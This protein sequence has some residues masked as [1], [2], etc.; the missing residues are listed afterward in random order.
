MTISRAEKS[1]WSARARTLAK[2]LQSDFEL[3]A[4]DEVILVSLA[5][6][7]TREDECHGEMH[8]KPMT[9][10][11]RFGQLI[12]HPLIVEQRQLATLIRQLTG[13]LRVPEIETD[14]TGQR[15]EKAGTR[16][17]RRATTRSPYA[18][19]PLRAVP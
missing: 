19:A 15:T 12:A 8:G 1:A 3:G 9:T 4:D 7:I 18:P 16:K 5:R 10:E 6:A 17:P 13:Q 2:A 14:S 11:D